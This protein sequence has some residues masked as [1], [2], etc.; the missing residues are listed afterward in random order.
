MDITKSCR[1]IGELDKDTQVI[2]RRFLD[3]CKKQNLNVLI[4]ET[5][6]SQAR[7]NYLYEQGRSRPGNIVTWTKSSKHTSRRAFD[8]C[9]NVKGQEYSD[10]DFFK[11]CAEIGKKLGLECGY[12]WTTQDKPHF[13]LPVGFIIEEEEMT[14]QIY[15]EVN[16]VKKQV[17][18]IEKDGNNYIKLQDL[19]DEKI[20]VSYDS[21]QKIPVIDVK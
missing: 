1:D 19:R 17:T 10:G 21:V 18:A 13:E 8:I 11:K 7:Q 12:Y 16:G 5:Y 9:K 4:T 15:I 2:C 14:K 6:R 3:E 20:L